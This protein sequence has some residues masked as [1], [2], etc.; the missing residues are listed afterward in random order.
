MPPLFIIA[1]VFV[2][3]IF[4]WIHF[5]NK[6]AA[7]GNIEIGDA[8]LKENAMKEGVHTTNSGLQ[9]T[10]L[11]EGN[12]ERHPTA[13]SEVTVHYHG[14]LL[15]GSVFDS[16]V[17]RGQPINFPLNRVIPGWS[18]GVQLMVEGEKRRFFIPSYLAYGNRSAG[19]IQ[20][21]STLIFDVELISIND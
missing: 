12:G 7:A 8:F 17:N 10:V 21:G 14:T 11:E 1:V 20:P 6:R 2:V 3:I 13:K 18:E 15:D 19:T 4:T 5:K 9:Y 16:S